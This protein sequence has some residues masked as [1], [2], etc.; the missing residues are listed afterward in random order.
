[1]SIEQGQLQAKTV[2][3]PPPSVLDR[4]AAD[5]SR[6]QEPLD[7]EPVPIAVNHPRLQPL[8]AALSNKALSCATGAFALPSPDLVLYYGKKCQN[9]R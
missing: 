7:W 9:T 4:I 5:R 2:P 6:N 1:M 3:R 8:H